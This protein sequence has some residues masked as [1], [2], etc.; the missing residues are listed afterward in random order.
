MR[1]TQ[2]GRLAGV[3]LASMLALAACGS[4]NNSGTPSGGASASGISCTSGSIKA[5]GSSAQ[6]NAMTEWIKAYQT[7]CSGATI[8]YQPTGSGQGVTDFNN[9]QTSFAGSD[10]ALK[11]AE[12]ASAMTRC[13]GNPAIDIPMVVGPIAIAYNVSGVSKLVLSSEVIAKIF[14]G[15]ITKWNDPAIVALNSGVTLP[16][17]SI[18]AFHRSEASGTTDNFAKFL[19]AS[20]SSVWTYPH[21]KDWPKD[22]KTGQG[23]KGSDG[24]ASAIKSTANSVGYVEYSF[25][26]NGGLAIAQVDNGGGPVELTPESAGKALDAATI[27]GTGN[28]LTL[29]LDYK[30]KDPGTY[31]IV[32]VTYEITCQKGLSG[33]DLTLTKSFL[34]Y[35]SSAAGQGLLTQLGYG[36]LPAALLTKAQASVAAIS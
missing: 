4:D 29:T 12:H 19:G 2:M 21:A 9:N 13:G 10:S 11:D 16:D 25:A 18:A 1:I 35:T 14:T 17:A 36:P 7:A 24:V 31:P 34:T 23:A 5:S 27:T 8:N 6:Q 30:V 32:L 33:T 20:A 3:T 28:D 15:A 22:I 26:K